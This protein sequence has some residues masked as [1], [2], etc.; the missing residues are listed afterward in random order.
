MC[1]TA[2]IP[3]H[4]VL[5]PSLGR[6][7]GDFADLVQRLRARGFT[8]HAMEPPASVADGTTL[9][10]LATEVVSRLDDAAVPQFHLVGHAFGNRLA[11]AVTA[12]FP[13]RVASLTLLAAGGFDPPS[14]EV[15]D[16]LRACF[17]ATLPHRE[18]LA[19][20]GR[21]FFAPGHD[22]SV[23]A[24]GWMF[25]VAAYQGAALGATPRD[26]WWD[27]AAP[28]VLVI[29]GLDDLVAPPQNGRRY[30]GDHPDVARLVEI[31]DAGHALIVEQPERVG[32][33]I[34]QFLLDDRRGQPSEG[35]ER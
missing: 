29:Q 3:R 32:E 20:V 12:D 18:R 5:L 21:A 15:A 11:R 6:P 33:T 31:R 24:S 25:D 1:Y 16:S 23:W 9:H 30:V 7:A 34:V 26:D 10:G 2:M 4:V 35:P 14:A 28:R 22:P 17:D 8:T 27:A 19:Q 13:D